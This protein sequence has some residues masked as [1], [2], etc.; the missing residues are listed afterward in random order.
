MNNRAFS[1]RL[2]V[3]AA[4]LLLVALLFDGSISSFLRTLVAIE[5]AEAAQVTIEGT[6]NTSSAVHTL[7]GSATVFV[8]DLVGYKFFRYGAA[9]SSG[10]CGY[11]KT[12]NGGTSWGSFVVT[13]TQTDCIGIAVWYD[14]WTPSATGTSIHIVTIDTGA[15]EMFY[16]RLETSNDT[17]LL[18]TATSTCLGCT[19][20]YSEATNK[21]SITRATNG[22]IYVVTDDGNGTNIRQCESSCNVSTNWQIVGT[23]PQGN[24]DSW[25]MLM[26]QAGG[27]VMLINRS[28]ANQIRSTVW[29]GSFWS[30]FTTIDA[31]AI[32]NT[33]YDVGMAVT[34]DTDSN[35]LYLIYAADNDTFTT[36]DHDIRSAIY[37]GGSWTSGT[38][39][40]TNTTRGVLQVAIARDQNTGAIYAAYTARTTIG[41]AATANVYWASSTSALSSWGP[42]QGPVNSAAADIYGVDLNIMGFERL[43]TSWY[44]VGAT[45]ILGDTLADIGPEIKLSATSTQ[46]ATVRSGTTNFSTGGKFVLESRSSQTVS[47]LSITES[48][49][50]DAQSD[51]ENIKLF[52]DL[53]TSAPYNCQSESYSGSE[54]QFGSTITGGFS[55]VNGV[56]AF[57]AS[58]LS[59]SPTQT[60]C[61]YVVL[62]VR[63][64]ANN[65][66]TIE[67]EV[68]SPSVDV[69]VSG[70]FEVYPASSVSLAG[71][72]TVV[73]PN[74]T[75]YGYHWRLDNGS[76]VTASS[77]TLGVQNT[78]L[79]ALQKNVPRRLRVGVSN[80]GGTSTLSGA[81]QMQY[82]EAAP[83]CQDTTSWTTV[84]EA[85]ADWIM[86]DSLNLTDGAN[87]TNIA[88]SSGGITD[89]GTT[90]F[91]SNAGVRDTSSSTGA[92]ILPQNNYVEFEFSILATSTATEGS[93][94]CFR[95][96]HAG[97]PLS[98]YT[99][100]PT[101][102]IAA[103]VTVQ[104]FGTA[105][106]SVIAG[107]NQV[108]LGGAFRVIE[109]TSSRS[110]TS[111]RL[112][113]VGS[114]VA[115]TSLANTRLR[116]EFDTSAPYNCASESYG[117]SESQF[118]ATAVNGF[119][120][121][122]EKI[123][124]TDSVTISTTSSLCLYVITDVLATAING[125]TIDVRIDT[126][127]TDVV[128][129]GAGSV[130]P[131]TPADIASSTVVVAGVLT[132]LAYH[133][134]LDNGTE[135]TASSAT[136]GLENTPMTE[137][138][139]GSVARLRLAITNTGSV[140]AAPAR[141]TLEYS[142]KITTC[143]DAT[144]WTNINNATDGWDLYDSA[145][146]TDGTNTTDIPIASGGVANGAGSFVAANGGVRDQTAYSA[147]TTISN[148]SYLDVEFSLSSSNLTSFDTTYCFRV[149]EAG[150]TLSTYTQYAELTTAPKR[151]FKIQRGS[152]QVSGT[153]T[154]LVAG[155][156]YIAPA[157]STRAFFR[158]TN[159]HHSGAGD[160][161]A[162]AGQ[163]VDDVTVH[164][165]NPGNIANNIRLRRPNA[166]TLNTRVDWEI[167][168]FI[169]NPETDNEIIVRGVGTTTM[170]TTATSS[171]LTAITGIAD[172]ADVVVFITG[173]SND[174]ASR[175][176]YAAHV[177]SEWNAATNQAIF[178]RGNAGASNAVISYAIVEFTGINWNIQ[179]VQHSYAASGVTETESITPVNSLSRTFLHTQRR[180][181][182]T[183]N[184]VH[185]GHE[186]WLSSIGAVSFQLE[187]GA[188]VAVEQTS[189][190]W[191]IENL[192]NGQ[193]QLEV[194]RSSGTTNGGTGPLSLSI[195][196]SAPID[197]LNNTSI[198]AN[199]RAAGANTTYPRPQAGF[200]LTSTT[201]YQIWRSNTGSVLTYRV[202]IIEW[203]VADLS[204][205]QNYYR[206]YVHNN[207]VTPDDPWPPGPSQL[208][209]NTSVTVADEPLGTGDRIRVRTTIRVVNASMPAGFANFKLQYGLR[210]TT[211]SAIAG[212]NW[213]DVGSI[214]GGAIW[215]GFAATG[216]IDGITV[217]ANP[218]DPGELLI[219]V[220][221]RGGSL[222]H[223][224]PSPE[225]PYA[226]FDGDTIEYDWHLEHNG[227]VP[228]STYCFR[229]VRSDGT[230]L[231]S[232][233]YYPQIRTASFSPVTMNWRWYEGSSLET[234]VVGLALENVA[235]LDIANDDTL[236][237]RIAVRERRG[238]LGENIKYR[239]QFSEDPTFATATDMLATSTCGT[240]SYWCY[241]DGPVPDNTKIS[242][243]LLSDVASSSC[244]SGVGIGCGTH[245][246][247]PEPELG[248]VHYA[249]TAQE[250]SFTLQ[251]V[252]AR[253][254]AVYYFR[255]YDVTNG[256]PV[257]P[258]TGESSPSLVTEGPTL[259]LS[260]A[261]LPVGTTTAGLTTNASTTPLAIEFGGLMFGVD[262]IAAH[263]LSIETNA[264]EG[265]QV[266]KAATQ[267]LSSTPSV[268]IQPVTGTNLSPS[269]WNTGC[270]IVAVGCV[271][272][273][274]T[275]A[276][277]R[278]GSTRFGPLDTYA[279]LSVEP[280][281]VMYS[282]VPAFDTHDIVYRVRVS[283]LQPAGD[284][285]TNITYIAIPVY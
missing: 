158:I 108:Y 238:V 269:S 128:V 93:T 216:T 173:I 220:A 66:D 150:R 1:R 94:Y 51:L 156:N 285:E 109:N 273:H 187:T 215:R 54:T 61:F 8:D 95:M 201:T 112:S 140:A 183:T 98:V 170:N 200:T 146:L 151:D 157:S 122:G 117:G 169:G 143:S 23:A 283:E 4:T 279:G 171:T 217:S 67:L 188:S 125:Q 73:D 248:H 96:I 284:Y 228:Q 25:S 198:M 69:V 232:Y 178:R 282:S 267:P 152:T 136:N 211:C 214:S 43:F 274:T 144:V 197:A 42:E 166:A 39:I 59:I 148:G 72:T 225:N 226:A 32:R 35:D 49:T 121:S 90:F 107:T 18:T 270:S 249:G 180:M 247:S 83:T 24:A 190:A 133:W 78:G 13:D 234:P 129:S 207:S 179:R 6:P 149:V 11:R 203:P 163:N 68:A 102:T 160:T 161:S 38:N 105:T 213:F 101:V 106:S 196:F 2:Q 17:L 142:P 53:D 115:S 221:N 258:D 272:Y 116:Y 80:Q 208:G 174:N 9:P 218:P 275:D 280:V 243:P 222:V 210:S 36:A 153:S 195:S 114:L 192:Q 34:I 5:M 91:V 265:Y 145:F 65:N 206:F 104:A 155:T 191:I 237:L 209:E 199:T 28:T 147:T 159:S 103:D 57:T 233:L 205:R 47:S 202:E 229:M 27:N 86:S 175:N 257:V 89:V 181:G 55:G 240:Q 261:G 219:S 20:T 58:P 12:T 79:S 14:Q 82:G 3:A 164:I 37:S 260:V 256:S 168:E 44:S 276:T 99:H 253:V 77:A 230:P 131:S 111:L 29:N 184:V 100:Y 63:T 254:H 235:P 15:D 266:L 212:G 62:D 26:P 271:G 193:G 70:G 127:V 130:G 236:T 223:Q 241:S 64:S 56:A 224:N 71:T 165:D 189:V 172:D 88:T 50:I 84:S 251:N 245:N 246:S 124:F 132:Q 10:A 281:E 264:T 76:E 167:V 252:A 60:A 31:S 97:N 186:V 259:N 277:L 134:R 231:D 75:Q 182:A 16:N 255:L 126:P 138:L 85:G 40:L 119:T 92:F 177:T 123:T 204:L 242:N 176:F 244:V 118:G 81:Y 33:T 227:A 45:D 278:G 250:Y 137:V 263:R 30:S 46:Q 74:L 120:E 19:G 141:F 162:T 185:F 154:L 22:T 110:V 262:Y 139:P 239:L 113:E 87:T 7:A 21:P 268:V 48:G 135:T 194:Q 41:T 52:Y